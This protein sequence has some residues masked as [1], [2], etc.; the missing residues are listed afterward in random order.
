M[1]TIIKSKVRNAV[2]RLFRSLN[3]GAKKSSGHMALESGIT[4]KTLATTTSSY[5]A[6]LD[7]FENN[8]ARG[9][10]VNRQAPEDVFEISVFVDGI[11]YCTSENDLARRDLQAIGKSTGKG[12][13]E[14][15]I[16][17]KLFDKALSVVSLFFPDGQPFAEVSV[18]KQSVPT[19]QA[20]LLPLVF[21]PV[22]VIVPIYNAASD[23]KK[24]INKLYK[25]TSDD[26]RIILIDD[27][28][29]DPQIGALLLEYRNRP[30]CKVH[31]NAKNLGY[32][33]TVNLGIQL[34]G[35]SDVVLLNSDARVTPRWLQGIQTALSMDARIATITPM[36]DKAGA[37]S[38]PKIGNENSLP[39]GV[40]EDNYAVAFRR[41]AQGHYPTV[42]TGNG[43]CMYIR[44]ETI[45]DIG[46]FDEEAFPR[47]YG[48]ENDFCM[49]ARA[50]GWRHIIDDRTYIFH[51]RN[52]SF[53]AEKATLIEQGRKVI[54]GRYPDYS[55]A[56]EIFS[57][58]GLIAHA[59]SRAKLALQDVAQEILPRGLF[60][61]STLTGGTPQTNRDLMRALSNDVEAW[62]LHCDC[63][64]MTL[65]KINTTGVDDIKERHF[66]LDVI[67]PLTHRS[68][69]YDSVLKSWMNRYDFEFVHIRH[70]AWHSINLPSVAKLAGARV[71]KSFH[72]YYT[73]C[74]TVKLL[75]N[76]N[77]FC[78]GVCT[79]S[80]GDCAPEL[81]P[82]NTFPHLK[83]QWVHQ[84]REK[85][86]DALMSCD[87]FVT[88]HEST[89]AIVSGSLDI[90]KEA[91]SVI[92]HGRDFEEFLSL[93]SAYNAGDTLRILIPGNINEAKGSK[94]IQTLLEIDDKGMLEFHILGTVGVDFS[95]PRIT[96]HG[97]YKRDEFAKH[98]AE[99]KPHVGAV[100]SI[101]N[102]TFCHTLTE[103]WSVGLPVIATDFDTVASRVEDAK[104]G[105]LINSDRLPE[106][107]DA[108][109][110]KVCLPAG[111]SQ[112]VDNV[113]QHQ[114]SMKI[115]DTKRMAANYL[116]VYGIR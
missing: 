70:L 84:W 65:F 2:R 109:L 14:I 73:V 15:Y 30:N 4:Y 76:N 113:K 13:F 54:D 12:G 37:F 68:N 50:M 46:L 8:V 31:R 78:N 86:S 58:S 20:P 102:E 97:S 25:H 67:D 7:L 16:P 66:L 21:A 39:S 52:Q 3:E 38:A 111:H 49:K 62:L 88:T 75:D 64:V 72:D 105:I 33:K 18:P 61:V 85:F 45:E 56:I 5:E 92:P 83:N 11:E 60:V 71:I 89:K 6:H 34:A 47:G 101:W 103:L 55:K 40:S 48:E 104:G 80:S 69:E 32:T 74:P 87:A 107:Y 98:V 57:K 44:R 22:T 24:C 53:G 36:S 96:E 26:V 108:I 27:A 17:S 99:I 51:E 100:L 1:K 35:D 91:I 93:S 23:V 82:Q 77:K 116:K 79:A 81:W 59:R 19:P 112:L 10:A 29:S 114:V 115:N 28:S 63:K 43:F 41:R 95:H 106:A 9:W 94:I 42:P 90:G 110:E